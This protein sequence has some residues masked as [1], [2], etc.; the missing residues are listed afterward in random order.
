[1]SVS[2]TYLYTSQDNSETFLFCNFYF[3]CCPF[4]VVVTPVHLLADPQYCPFHPMDK[5]K[6]CRSQKAH[7]IRFCLFLMIIYSTLISVI[8]VLL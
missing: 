6:T 7:W 1:M 4:P 3:C 2:A 8:I 5:N